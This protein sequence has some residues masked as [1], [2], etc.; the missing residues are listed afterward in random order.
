MGK[1]R[2]VHYHVYVVLLDDSVRR[3]HKVKALN[4]HRDRQKPCIYVGMTG[5]DPLERFKKHKAGYKSS[6]YVRKYGV[7]LL[8]ELYE[9]LNPMTYDE[10]VIA[11]QGLARR[12]REEGYMVVG[13]H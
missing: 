11:E 8:P 7:R 5:L 4:P 10:A 1:T 3:I 13:G 9:G 2:S 12:L 6:K